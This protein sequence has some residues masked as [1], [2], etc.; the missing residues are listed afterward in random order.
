MAE[1]AM[2]TIHPLIFV[3]P[4]ALVFWSV[5]AWVYL[6]EGRQIQRKRKLSGGYEGDDRYSGLVISVGSSLLQLGALALAYYQPLSMGQE[7]LHTAFYAGLVVLVTGTLLRMHCWKALGEF[8][9][10][11]VTIAKD[12]QVV[13]IGAYRFLRHPA[14]L[15]GWLN[16]I[17]LGVIL[18]NYGSVA[19][20]TIGAFGIF[21]YRIE[22]EEKALEKGLGDA[23]RQFKQSRKR[24]IP[25]VY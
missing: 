16:L 11:T 20:I 21:H 14:Y 15:G 9:T 2:P 17:G 6:M 1:L 8:F 13:N 10:H 22:V 3:W 19:L 18:G 25:F 4:E 24:L 23:Y 7:N 5:L 12:H